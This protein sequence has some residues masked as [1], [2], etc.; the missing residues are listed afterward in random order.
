LASGRVLPVGVF[1][2]VRARLAV[3]GAARSRC[4]PRPPSLQQGDVN[5]ARTDR[6]MIRRGQRL[7]RV[8]SFL[9]RLIQSFAGM[10]LVLEASQFRIIRLGTI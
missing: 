4:L 1:G 8:C 9:S 5:K 2:G 10:A 7:G 3:T 6:T